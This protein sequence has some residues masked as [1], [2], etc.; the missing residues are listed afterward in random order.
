MKTNQKIKTKI[1]YR[2]ISG[3]YR[4]VLGRVADRS[5]LKK[6]TIFGGVTQYGGNVVGLS[7]YRAVDNYRCKKQTMIDRYK[8]SWFQ[9]G[10]VK[11]VKDRK[12][13]KINKRFICRVSF[14]TN[15]KIFKISPA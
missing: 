1:I 5:L 11:E 4:S 10:K 14:R 9:G 3:S 13:Q 8:K 7:A 15:V 2:V 12:C 6:V